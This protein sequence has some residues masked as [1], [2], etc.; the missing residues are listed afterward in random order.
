MRRPLVIYDFATTPFWISLYRKILFSFYQCTAL[1]LCP[2]AL[3]PAELRPPR[4]GSPRG[5]GGPGG[6]LG[7]RG[8]AAPDGPSAPS[9]PG[10]PSQPFRP[11]VPVR[12]GRP[13]RPYTWKQNGKN[14]RTLFDI[15]HNVCIRVENLDPDSDGSEDPDLDPTSVSGSSKSKDPDLFYI[16]MNASHRA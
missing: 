1:D 5:P 7:P 4:P 6:P 13:G 15:M 16:G 10:I 14:T 9:H 12:P 8:P 11:A 2:P 3:M